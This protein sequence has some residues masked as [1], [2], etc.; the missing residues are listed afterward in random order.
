MLGGKK[1]VQIKI[2]NTWPR[3][4]IP[5]FFHLENVR[6]YNLKLA[7]LMGVG[8]ERPQIKSMVIDFIIIYW[9]TMYIFLFRNPVIMKRM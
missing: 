1:G 7:Y 3:Y 2:G 9:I 4:A 6:D 5:F 8:I